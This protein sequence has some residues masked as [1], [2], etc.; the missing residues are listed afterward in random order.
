MYRV[1]IKT[2]RR[3]SGNRTV[4]HALPSDAPGPRADDG[5]AEGPDA[6]PGQVSL[7]R[8]SKEGTREAKVEGREARANED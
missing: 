8:G 7:A 6:A 5:A 3:L 4:S 2:G 1:H